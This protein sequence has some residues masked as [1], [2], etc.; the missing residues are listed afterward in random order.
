MGV[1]YTY[2][3]TANG[4]HHRSGK[5]DTKGTSQFMDLFDIFSGQ[6]SWHTRRLL[7]LAKTLSDEQLDRPLKN[8]VKTFPWE[9][10]DQ[11]LR[12]LLDRMVQT[13]EAWAAALT[14]GNAPAFDKAPAENR[15]PSA[16]L[17]RLEEADRGFNNVLTDVRNRSA[18]E[19]TFVDALCEP[20]ETFT[21]GGMFAHVITFN[22]Y[23]RMAA[24]DVLRGLGVK[25]DGFG[26]PM[27]YLE[28]VAKA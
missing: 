5:D 18:W 21:F 17:T 24:I 19:D 27:E 2:L 6:E 15:T 9:G 22:A 10:P 26:C 20:P 25:V 11:N 3:H 13:K 7:D 16:M 14:G 8:Q 1:T 4:I 28:S 12:Q 23:R